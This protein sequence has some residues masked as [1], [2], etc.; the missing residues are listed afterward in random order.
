MNAHRLRV[1]Q[2]A[3]RLFLASAIAA[4]LSTGAIARE[5]T[6]QPLAPQLKMPAQMTGKVIH[7][8]DGDT[9]IMLDEQ[10]FKRVIRLSDI[11]APETSHGKSRPGQP[12]SAK[13]TELLKAL[14]HGQHAIANCFDIDVRKRD[15]GTQRDRYVCQ[16]IA[17]QTDVNLA[18]ID[19][20]MAM[21][22]R[23]NKRYVRNPATYWHEDAARASRKGLWQ[24]AEPIPP[25]LW[26][27]ACWE[28]GACAQSGN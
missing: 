11:D 22:A 10:G 15:D 25:W 23:Q 27:R 4:V 6:P 12:Y 1:R 3:N 5:R 16:V 18:L 26:R 21:A 17:N 20:G 8:D 2:L 9:L 28:Q 19:A 24:Q 14:A 7:I 13:A